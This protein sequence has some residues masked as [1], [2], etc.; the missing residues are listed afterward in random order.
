MAVITRVRSSADWR[1]DQI[2]GS[3]GWRFLLSDT[4][5]A[6]L[7]AALASAQAAGETL[8]GISRRVFPLPTLGPELERLARDVTHGLGFT[9]VQGVPVAELGEY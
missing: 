6:E 5:Q 4:H 1:G 9:L 3:Q 8:G 2:A 7:L